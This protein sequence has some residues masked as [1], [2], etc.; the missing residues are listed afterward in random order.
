M[1]DEPV[2]LD[3]HRGLAALKAVE[4]RRQRLHAFEADRAA[5]KRQRQ[6]L[7][8]LLS[9]PPAETWLEAAA[10]AKFLI[11]LLA[12]ASEAQEPRR[13]ELI[14]QT[15]GDLSRLSDREQDPA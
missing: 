6:D 9:A 1:T 10:K 8:D 5:L 13:K 15:L 11:E 14:A 12:K 7:E 2:D 3:E 4:T